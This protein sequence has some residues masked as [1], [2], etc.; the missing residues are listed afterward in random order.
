[1]KNLIFLVTI[2]LCFSCK[3]N[4][5]IPIEHLHLPKNINQ[6]VVHDLS[7]VFTEIQVDSLTQKIINY[8]DLSTNEIA[9][10][11]VDSILPYKDLKTY[12]TSIGNFWG[13][14]KKEKDNGLIII[15][16]KNQRK[17]W[18]STGNGTERVLTDSI[19]QEIIKSSILPHFKKENYYLGINNGLDSIISKWN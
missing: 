10:L 2:L 11:T 14:G 1:M 8:E 7:K 19:C 3:T 17:I 5:D 9:I 13:I 12:G 16:L 6:H 15:L 4:T 18:I